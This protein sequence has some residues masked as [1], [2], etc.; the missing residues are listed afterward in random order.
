ML[1]WIYRIRLLPV[2]IFVMGLTLTV[3]VGAIWEGFTV[4]AA[5]A[6]AGKQP[7]AQQA[8]LPPGKDAPKDSPKD[9]KGAP[10]AE[11]TKLQPPAPGTPSTKAATS[12]PGGTGSPAAAPA[13][14][15]PARK[16][17]APSLPALDDPTLFTQAEIDLLQQLAD[18]REK[19]EARQREMEVREGMFNAAEARIDKKIKELKELR[20]TIEALVKTHDEQ[21]KAKIASL[22]KIY[23]NMKPQDAARIFEEMEMDT[24]LQVVEKMQERRLAPILA[25]MNPT[26]AK[27][28]SVELTRFKKIPVPKEDS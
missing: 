23:E 15:P 4:P 16:G 28:V 5:K 2:A 25:K 27:E 24:L 21:Q 14:P 17:G 3:K 10:P 26:K 1:A 11:P 6:Q 22:V 19:L 18:R 20:T 12:A 8:Q 9:A 13:A 7:S